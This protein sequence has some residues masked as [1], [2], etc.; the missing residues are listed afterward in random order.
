MRRI[1]LEGVWDLRRGDGDKLPG[2]L[3]GCTYLDYIANGMEDPF[4]GENEREATKLA[5]HEFWYSRD[6]YITADDL[7]KDKVELVIDGLDTVCKLFL[8]GKEFAYADNLFRVWRFDIKPLVKEGTNSIELNFVDPYKEI[9]RRQVERP[10]KN[11]KKHLSQ[12]RVAPCHFGWDWGPELYPAGITRSINIEA[13]NLRLDDVKITQKHFDGKVELTVTAEIIGNSE[14]SSSNLKLASPD[15]NVTVLTGKI[16]SNKITFNTMITDPKLWWCNGLGEQS[17]YSVDIEL[18]NNGVEEDSDHK[19]IGLRTI[20]LDTSKD[21]YGEQF[22][23]VINSIPLFAR[24]ANWIPADTFITRATRDKVEFDI[25]AAHTANMNM[26]RVWGGGYYESEDFYDLCDKYGILVWQD[27]AFCCDAYPFFDKDFLENVRLEVVDNV[28]RLRHRA[29]L[30]IWS[31][32]NENEAIL[33][34]VKDELIKKSNK[35]FYYYILRDWVNDLDGVT[36]YWPG[37]PSSGHPDV[38]VHIMKKGKTC[39]DTH[40]WHVWHGTMPIEAFRDLHTRFCSEFGMESMP[41]MKAVRSFTN[42]PKP[43]LLD[44]TMLLH[45]K[46]E[47][48]NEKILYYLL[49]KYREPTTFEDFA[50]LS[51]IVQ[52]NA[53]RFATDTWRRNFGEQNGAIFWQL[54]DCW[55]VAS[56]SG[57]DYSKQLKAV[58][59]HARHFNKPLCL[60]NDYYDNRAEIYVE[61]DYPE[62]FSGEIEWTLKDFDGKHVNSGKAMAEVDKTSSKRIAV[63]KFSKIL[64]GRKKTEVALDVKLIGKNGEIDRKLW[65]LVPDK[66]AKLP[67][68]K[69]ETTC[70]VDNGVA[71]VTLTSDKYARYVFVDALDVYAPWSDNYFDIPAGESVTITADVPEGMTAEKFSEQL[72]VKTLTDLTPKNS[73][74]WEKWYRF[75]L[76]ASPKT[77]A[78]KLL[79]KF[80]LS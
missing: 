33:M 43:E 37:C 6:F 28:K 67:K 30:A 4:W 5:H 17:L 35:D 39:G 70:K 64:K 55:P 18:I 41:S 75:K 71:T 2:H 14:G 29:S 57:I 62:V 32:N 54:N 25:K 3:P 53:V 36:P 7:E 21:V 34:V 42:N 66:L 20:E 80:L 60:S 12:I 50:Y 15:G 61:N 74:A 27:F 69:V 63:L 31:G 9:E 72:T 59:Y 77:I 11:A 79:F 10:F 19:K 13:Y 40:L 48:G 49:A 52:S 24:G 68:V 56:W 23:F 46:S 1:S 47:I 58:M 44:S 51:Q 78:T 26:I 8:N 16:E 76:T 38:R 45:Q 22:R 73:I 65:L